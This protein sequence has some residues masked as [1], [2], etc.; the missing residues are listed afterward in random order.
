MPGRLGN[1]HEQCLRE[2]PGGE[3]QFQVRVRLMGVSIVLERAVRT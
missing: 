2:R 3:L 1:F